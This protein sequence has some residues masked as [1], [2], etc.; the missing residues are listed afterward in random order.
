VNFTLTGAALKTA[1]SSKIFSHTS[2]GYSNVGPEQFQKTDN[3]S[4]KVWDIYSSQ[5]YTFSQ[6]KGEYHGEGDCWNKEHLLPQG[7]FSEQEPM[8][9]DMHH[10][11]PT[12]GYVNNRRSNYPHAM[13][14]TSTRFVSTNGTKI[15]TS[16]TDGV[17][18]YVCEPI[19]EFKGDIARAIFYMVT[20][21]QDK[22]PAWK[23]YAVL[24][25]DSYPS[26]APWAITLY[27]KWS[28]DD[29]VNQ[30]EIDRNNAIFALQKNRNPFVDYPGIEAKIW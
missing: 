5:S 16:A 3:L 8:R 9:S 18:G 13:V 2:L 26:L 11:Y 30:K 28:A 23:N 12:D 22:L 1:L 29:P 24:T 21:Y 20:A 15:G 4:G 6:N 14:G 19:N 27:K 10:L 17:T 7:F 25:K